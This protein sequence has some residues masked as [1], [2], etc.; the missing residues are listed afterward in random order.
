VGNIV[1]PIVTSDNDGKEDPTCDLRKF[2]FTNVII[3]V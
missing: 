1:I 3:S 2:N